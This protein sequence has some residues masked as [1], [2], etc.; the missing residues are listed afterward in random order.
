MGG[1]SYTIT[2]GCCNDNSSFFYHAFPFSL[3][4][5]AKLATLKS[6]QSA[7]SAA[8]DSGGVRSCFFSAMSRTV[9]VDEAAF[10]LSLNSL[11][12]EVASPDDP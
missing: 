1:H 3:R 8:L 2:P 7:R 11:G 12:R 6:R 9:K 5:A 4:L 10:I